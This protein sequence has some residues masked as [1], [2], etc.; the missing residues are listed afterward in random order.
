MIQLG[1]LPSKEPPRLDIDVSTVK[2]LIEEQFSKW[3]H[4]EI[5]P[6]KLSGWDNR[7]FH[8]GNE[9]TVR[10]PSAERYI[11]QVKK[12]QEWLPILKPQLSVPI[13]EP[14]AMGVPSERYPW[15][16]SI[17][18]W[19]EGENADTLKEENFEIFALDAAS[20]LK[21]LH[22][23]N[24]NNG[25]RPGPFQ[26]G[27]PPS[28]YDSDTRKYLKHLDGVI[29]TKGAINVWEEAI[30]SKWQNDPVWVHGDFSIGNILVEK[31][32]LKAVIDFGSTSVGDPSC[33]LVI[34]WTF[35]KGD[36]RK[37]DY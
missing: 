12:E 5:R 28:F 24:S 22:K 8:L 33:D 21:E 6:V 16:W 7:T 19:I 15:N 31:G 23:A 27:G 2:R 36:S 14:L 32:K 25:P 3:A 11:H 37:V 9:M 4:L 26:R 30:S 35:L 18:R 29:D 13:P 10:L 34:A 20:F 1:D 17:Y